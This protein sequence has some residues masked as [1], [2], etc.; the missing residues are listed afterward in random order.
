[1]Q[2]VDPCNRCRRRALKPPHRQLQGRTRRP[3][4]VVRLVVERTD[5]LMGGLR[6]LRHQR[7]YPP[8]VGIRPRQTT[9]GIP[10]AQWRRAEVASAVDLPPPSS[11]LNAAVSEPFPTMW[12]LPELMRCCAHRSHA[13][14][15]DHGG[16]I[17]TG[18]FKSAPPLGNQ[19][20]EVGI[21]EA[22][23]SA[24]AGR[25]PAVAPTDYGSDAE[26]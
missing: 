18:L 6:D 8:H 16:Q 25:D 14:L 19:L 24:T 4:R 15:R 10:Q 11:W 21:E 7:Y 12:V 1:M 20:L 23:R 17:A 9:K 22:A 13:I 5:I 26:G 3:K 2:G